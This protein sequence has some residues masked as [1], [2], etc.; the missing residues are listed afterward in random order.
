MAGIRALIVDD[1]PLARE[2][3]R[4]RLRDVTD[5]EI[6]GEC[7]NGGEALRAIERHRPD[8]VFLDIQMP[9]LSGFEVIERLAPEILPVIIFVTAY[10]QYAL[11]AFRIHALDYLL[12]PFD[13]E[14]FTE[15]LAA[16]RCRVEEGRRAQRA[17]EAVY[18]LSG[19]V[20]AGAGAPG[21]TSGAAALRVPGGFGGRPG[22]GQAERIVI[23]ARGRVFFLKTSAIEWV[24]ANGDYARLHSGERSYLLRRTMTEMEERLDPRTFIRVSRS[25]IVNLDQIRD[26]VPIARG[27]YRVRLLTG[28]EIKLTRNYRE[29]LEGRL[30]DRL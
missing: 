6:A 11:E 13:D 29:K 9:D 20:T 2:N 22:A 25:A 14:R 16:C 5:F 30:G 4:I 3:L 24:E 27:E 19:G 28:A 18:Q 8:V 10:D 23:K 21:T 1:E 17:G 7:A 15:A 12:K 26:L